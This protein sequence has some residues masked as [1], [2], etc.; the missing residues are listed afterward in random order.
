M[1][2][3]TIIVVSEAGQDGVGLWVGRRARSQVDLIVII[4]T[5]TELFIVLLRPCRLSRKKEQGL[6]STFLERAL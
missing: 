4:P 6:K 3:T 5:R 1:V 2:L